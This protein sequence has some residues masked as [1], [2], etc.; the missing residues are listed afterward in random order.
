M[1]VLCPLQ[2]RL[3]LDGEV[4]LHGTAYTCLCVLVVWV[5]SRG[6]LGC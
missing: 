6:W 3:R 2:P 5:S 1:C 4:R